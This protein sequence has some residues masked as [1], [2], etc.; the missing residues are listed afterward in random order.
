[1]TAFYDFKIY[2]LNDAA[3]IFAKAE[4]G[5]AKNLLVISGAEEDNEEIK[6]FAGKILKAAGFTVPTD[7]LHLKLTETEGF[8]LTKLLAA[9]EIKN[10]IVFGFTPSFLGLNWQ[11]PLY[12]PFPYD[13]K[14]FLFADNLAKIKEDKA[15]KGKLW[16]SLKQMFL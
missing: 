9:A 10:V 1:M 4:G 12:H 11:L 6:E 8:S 5:N 16:G 7:V 3:E 14:G 2:P 13:E 15:L